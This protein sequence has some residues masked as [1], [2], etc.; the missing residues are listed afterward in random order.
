MGDAEEVLKIA[1]EW[2]AQGKRVCLATVIG[3]AGSAPR[4]V[5]AK[6]AIRD[7]GETAGSIGGGGLEK[8]I[9]TRARRALQ[10]GNAAVVE[11]DLSGESASLD[12]TCGGK[13]SVFVEP[14]GEVRRL[15]V[16]GA[17]HVGKAVTRMAAWV[18]FA[19]TVVDDREEYLG[20]D[21]LGPGVSA[22]LA[23]PEDSASKLDIDPS[24]FVVICTRGHSL[25]KDWLRATA[26]ANPRYV[27]MLGSSQKAERIRDEL[28]REGVS[29]EFLKKVRTPVGL[30]I[31]AVTPEEIAVSIVG[32]LILDWRKGKRGKA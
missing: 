28:R 23:L 1:N 13:V 18:G 5:G 6:M 22:V 3:R 26:N 29:P 27:G 8:E 15:F 9:I 11:F 32:E 7:D 24:A 12:A 21:S 16:I 30:A 31:E 20:K 4:E 2:L 14:L 10:D 19:V 25:D 17:G